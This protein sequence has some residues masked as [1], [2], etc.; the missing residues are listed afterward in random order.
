[1]K[2]DIQFLKE[3]QSELLNQPNDGQASPRF[4]VIRDYRTVP[5]HEDY[6]SGHHEYFHNDGDHVIFHNFADLKEFIEEYH[7]DEINEDEELRELLN[8]GNENFYGLWDYVEENLNDDGFF[9]KVFVKEEDFIVPD[10]MF[11]TK[12]EAERHL[13]LNHYH[14]TKKAHTYAMTAWRAPKIERL[15]KILETFNWDSVA[16]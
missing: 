8:D 14:Y 5:G 3:L 9:G 2:D 4:W 10:T 6:N 16:V 15:M 13:E 11:L 1:M 7:E 12:E